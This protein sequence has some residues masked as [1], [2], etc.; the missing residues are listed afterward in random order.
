MGVI[1]AGI[2]VVHGRIVEG[3]RAPFRENAYYDVV[4]VPG[5]S[6]GHAHPQVVDGGLRRGVRW[7]N[8]YEWIR[9]RDMV[10]DEVMVRRD[11]SVASKL[12]YLTMVRALLEGTTLLALTGRLAANVRAWFK[13]RVRPRLVLLPT[14]MDRVGWSLGEVVSDY[15]RVS[16]LVS[17][18]FARM[19][20]FIHS[21]GMAGV[22][23]IRESLSLASRGDGI[24][25]LHLGEGVSELEEFKR[26]LGEPPYPVKI[27]PVHCIDDDVQEVG[28]QCVSCPTTNI[29][30][31]GRTR[32]SLAGISSFGSDW[33]L[34]LGTTPK[35]LR[36]IR[37]VF[38]EPLE[39]I[40][41]TATIGGYKLYEIPYDGDMVAFDGNLEDVMSG[42]VKPKL[43]IVNNQIAV[44]DG[45][46]VDPQITV[47]D[48]EKRIREAIKEVS[49]K[50]GSGVQPLIPPK[51]EDLI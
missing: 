31:Y 13:L 35:H 17:D 50:Y 1:E 26:V 28:L 6:D 44:Y 18:G 32:G 39:V 3:F 24:V 36:L 16:M 45:A 11:L 47:E 25:G 22:T 12:S 7:R 9:E 5:F 33:P 41:R 29:I 30:L 20:V 10:V 21:L 43:V 27:I 42:Y 40:A 19:G 46:L 51:P 4:L 48:V 23:T 37:R 15:N 14:V 8:S 49:E 34:L 38:K 2:A